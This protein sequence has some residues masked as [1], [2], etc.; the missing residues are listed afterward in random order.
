[1]GSGQWAV[2]SGQWAVGSG[3]WAVGRIRNHENFGETFFF[4]FFRVN[5][6]IGFY[7]GQRRST[8]RHEISRTGF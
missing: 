6:W 2:G 5:S 8:K 7:L 1:V 4:V 3:Q